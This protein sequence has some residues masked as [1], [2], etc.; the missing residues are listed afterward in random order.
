MQD[1]QNQGHGV[2]YDGIDVAG[3]PVRL[4]IA[5]YLAAR[6]RFVGRVLRAGGVTHIHQIGTMGVP[7]VSDI[8]LIVTLTRRT[9]DRNVSLLSIDGLEEQDRYVFMHPPLFVDSETAVCAAYKFEIE[10]LERIYG[11]ASGA[12]MTLPLDDGRWLDLSKVVDFGVEL[13][14]Q[15]VQALVKRRI[16][17]RET[18]C[19]LASVRHTLVLCERLGFARVAREAEFVRDVEILRRRVLDLDRGSVAKELVRLVRAGSA[20]L[21]RVLRDAGAEVARGTV[22]HGPSSTALRRGPAILRYG[23]RTILVFTAL[24]DKPADL[25]SLLCECSY[26]EGGSLRERLRDRFVIPIPVGLYSHFACYQAGVGRVAR[27][28][29]KALIP[30]AD[31]NGRAW[32]GEYGELLRRKSVIADE[33]IAFLADAGLP[34]SQIVLNCVRGAGGGSQWRRMVGDLVDSAHCS[35]VRRKFRLSDALLEAVDTDAS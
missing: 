9:R 21:Y 29:R 13:L 3:W 28:F 22:G 4:N 27:H 15:F 23:W 35:G 26:T 34:P 20:V 14:V 10:S 8:D 32:A 19:L 6:D 5:D 18:L 25:E 16:A 1:S 17:V 11:D 12:F 2:V 7:G 24:P 30:K 31:S 33:H